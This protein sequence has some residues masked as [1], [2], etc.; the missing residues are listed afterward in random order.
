MLALQ[1]KRTRLCTEHCIHFYPFIYFFLQNF[2]NYVK[3][4]L[5]V[6]TIKPPPTAIL[7]IASLHMSYRQS[8]VMQFGSRTK[9]CVF[10]S[11]FSARIFDHLL[12][13]RRSS[14]PEARSQNLSTCFVQSIKFNCTFLFFLK[15]V[16]HLREPS[17]AAVRPVSVERRYVPVT[18]VQPLQNHILDWW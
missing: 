10:F 16:L 7:S 13:M 11:C 4:H 3:I 17:Q 18:W 14:A 12:W 1:C 5:S 8:K 2:M 9:F 6:T 15:M